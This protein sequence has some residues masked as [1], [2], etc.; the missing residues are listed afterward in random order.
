MKSLAAE[1]VAELAPRLGLKVWI[2]P[3]HRYV[4]QITLPNGRRSYFRNNAFDVNSQGAAELAKDKDYA[5]RFLAGMGFPVPEGQTFYSDAW[6]RTIGSDRDARAAYNYARK[7]GFP[8]IVKPNSE[9]HGLGVRR[10]YTRRELNEALRFVFR[11]ARDRVALVQRPINGKDYRLVLFD[12]DLICAYRRSPL[13]VIGD[14]RRPISTLFMDHL[15]ELLVRGRDIPVEPSDA[16]VLARLRR[17]HLTPESIPG[18]GERVVLLD[19]ANL[20]TGGDAEDVTTRLH[21]QFRALGTAVAEALGLRLCGI[22]L[23]TTRPIE[24]APNAYTIIEVNSAPGLDH[25]ARLGNAQ[26]R[27]VVGLYERILRTLAREES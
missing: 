9:S 24:E 16:R 5:A 6:C 21:P 14:G 27:V 3:E 22:D 19:N 8:V 23:M 18:A 17:L 25:F 4:G 7:I 1:M 26:H 13:A 20:S 2:E 10:A 11:T 15:Q 12:G